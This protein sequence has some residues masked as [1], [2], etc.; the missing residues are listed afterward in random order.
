MQLKEKTLEILEAN[1]TP[2]SG[3][4]IANRLGISRNMVWKIIQKLREEG[5]RIS[6]VTNRGYQLLSLGNVLTAQAVRSFLPKSLSDLEIEVRE[7][8]TSTNTLLKETAEQGGREG[9][10]LIAQEQTAGKGRLGRSFFSPADTGLYLSILLRPAYPAEQA[11]SITTAAAVSVARAIETTTGI[12]AQIKWVNDIYVGGK[13]VCGILT[14]A[15]LDFESGGLNY[16]IVGIGINV[17]EP[18]GGF[19]KE[20]KHTAGALYAA[21]LPDGLRAK[22]AAEVIKEFFEIYRQRDTNRYMHEYQ[23]R[24]FLTGLDITF[25]QGNCT[26]KG[27]VKGIDDQAR[28]IVRLE[29]GEERRYSAGEVQIH[30]DFAEQ[31]WENETE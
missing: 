10:V 26:E 5:Y 8:V 4:L 29:T 15:A 22:L 23:A 9:C 12:P 17:K 6:A 13:K 28:L 7:Q 3:E 20:L 1:Q 31:E 18:A 24:S 30:K 11:L 14:E 25:L 16:A 2:V 19:S 27:N 21:A